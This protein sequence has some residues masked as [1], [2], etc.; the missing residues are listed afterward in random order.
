MKRG[1]VISIISVLF[2][3]LLSLLV[4]AYNYPPNYACTETDGFKDPYIKGTVFVSG[5]GYSPV[6]GY[7]EADSLTKQLTDKCSDNEGYVIEYYC[8]NRPL[9]LSQGNY[10]PIY[11][12]TSDV[13]PPCVVKEDLSL[14]LYYE[15]VL[16]EHGCENGA[17]LY[18][19]ENV[20]NVQ[21]Q[22]AR[23]QMPSFNGFATGYGDDSTETGA[24]T[25]RAV[26]VN[27]DLEEAGN[28]HRGFLQRM[29]GWFGLGGD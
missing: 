1:I 15:E 12:V 29:L 4:V 28:R 3:S 23:E 6:E 11:F 20:G 21:E 8:S 2:I 13:K 9:D 7:C 19:Q 27:N 25:G 14:A 18:L 22:R 24:L 10:V 26:Q 5:S 17:C 16:C